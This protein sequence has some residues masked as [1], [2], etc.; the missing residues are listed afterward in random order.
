MNDTNKCLEIGTIQAFLDGELAA[1]ESLS[2][3]NHIADC[4]VCA[5]ALAE[6]ESETEMVFA[7]L[8]REY[9]TLVPTQRLWAKINDSIVEE[10]KSAS[11]WQKIRSFVSVSFINPSFAVAASIFVVVG[12]FAV[13]LL[14]R[15]AAENQLTARIGSQMQSLKPAEVNQNPIEKTP[16]LDVAAK[17]NVPRTVN[18]NYRQAKAKTQFTPPNRKLIVAPQIT[19]N[20]LKSEIPTTETLA[21]LPGEESYVKTIANLTQT[22][23]NSKNEVLNPSAQIAF[24]RDLAVVD[25]TITKMKLEVKKNPKNEAAKQVLY[26]SYQNK[27]DLLNSVARKN[28]LMASLK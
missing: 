24:S 7:A 26:S 19:N 17:E 2:V 21:Y 13:V 22:V 14:I 27:I 25:D 4:D 12:I 11:V 20:Q 5:N 3:S 6:A 18:A 8:D 9:N 15:P 16:K 23:D 28:E 10:K 1:E